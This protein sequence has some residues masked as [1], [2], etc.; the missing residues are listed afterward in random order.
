MVTELLNQSNVPQCVIYDDEIIIRNDAFNKL[1]GLEKKPDLNIPL[2]TILSYQ[3]MEKWVVETNGM[4]VQLDIS[5]AVLDQEYM[6]YTFAGKTK[7]EDVRLNIVS[8]DQSKKLRWLTDEAGKIIEGSEVG[9]AFL[10]IQ[11]SVWTFV[12]KELYNPNDKK[13]VLTFLYQQIEYEVRVITYSGYMLFD[14]V[15]AE[16][17]VE[18]LITRNELINILDLSNECYILHDSMTIHYANKATHRYLGMNHTSLIGKPVRHHIQERELKL[19]KEA[20]QAQQEEIMYRPIKLIN[21]DGSLLYTMCAILPVHIDGKKLFVSVLKQPHQTSKRREEAMK[22]ASRLS[23]SM[24]HE[25]RNPLTT[26]KGFMQLYAETKAI[27][28]SQVKTINAELTQMEKIIDDYVFLAKQ[29]GMVENKKTIEINSYVRAL[30]RKEEMKELVKDNPLLLSVSDTYYIHGYAQEL[31]ILFFNLIGNA[32]DASQS[33]T[34][35]EI[36]VTTDYNQLCVQVIDK[37]TGIPPNRLYLLGQPF[38]SSKEKGTGL[39]LMICHKIVEL[40]GGR[41]EIK[42]KAGT[43][44]IVQVYLPLKA[45]SENRDVKRVKK[46]FQQVLGQSETRMLTNIN[47]RSH[48]K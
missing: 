36:R 20:M 8:N 14:V 22:V 21:G 34:S 31:D 37:G 26:I 7:K 41:M 43:G 11:D 40:H 4:N 46:G 5:H 28:E 44:T 6:L 24:A 48:S 38:F 47:Q 2:A 9:R 45:V 17:R 29:K 32:V 12:P 15:R 1:L 10:T 30:A 16:Q 42:T 13:Q 19:V 27:P 35:I 25:L 23:A 3:S 33:A 18:Q 39:G